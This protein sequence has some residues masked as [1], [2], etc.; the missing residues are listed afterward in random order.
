MHAERAAFALRHLYVYP[1]LKIAYTYIPKN[2]CT[3]FKRTFGHAQG[4]LADDAP[5]DHGMRLDH[6]LT[7]IAVYP[8]SEERIV[9]IRDPFDRILSGYLNRFLMRD[10][11]VSQ[12][13]MSTGLADRVRPGATPLDVRFS[14]FVE[15]LAC[16][17]DHRLNEHWRPQRD[18]LVGT[19][20]R[21]IRFEH[22]AEDTTFLAERNL[23]LETA[24]G[25]AT[26]T[27]RRDLGSGW[28]ERRARRIR[29]VRRRLGA[30]PMRENMYDDRLH[31]LVA[32]RYAEDVELFRRGLVG[33]HEA[34]ASVRR[35]P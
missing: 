7:G 20:T 10:D 14:D 9:V 2:A 32:E 18:F 28:G 27:N 29:R 30:L 21:C 31:A 16:T 25:H 24:Q 33:A 1:R 19:Y 15:Y 22:I 34:T 13:A 26:S 8:R 5:N 3:S 23:T 12:H 11:A 4:W 35:T 17:P 6:W